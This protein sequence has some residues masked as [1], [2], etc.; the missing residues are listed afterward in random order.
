MNK[1]FSNKLNLT[2][3]L[4]LFGF[5]VFTSGCKKEDANTLSLNG[6]SWK[7]T[8]NDG[9]GDVDNYTLIFNESTFTMVDSW[10]NSGDTNS[11]STS[12][13]YTYSHPTV[14]LQMTDDSGEQYAISGTISKD[15]KQ[16]TLDS[17]DGY[18]VILTK[19]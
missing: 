12:G 4:A 15:G 1:I 6:T 19:Q 16:M 8:Y 18:N 10:N 7:G 5:M 11:Q 13:T 14:I 2:C 9:E 3:F 17:A